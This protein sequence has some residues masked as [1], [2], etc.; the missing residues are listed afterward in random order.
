MFPLLLN[1]VFFIFLFESINEVTYLYIHFAE[2]PDEALSFLSCCSTDFL[3]AFDSMVSSY[4][5]LHHLF[6]SY[7]FIFVPEEAPNSPKRSLNAFVQYV[8]GQ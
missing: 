6:S 5:S 1:R 8:Q 2:L 4:T 3:D 7:S